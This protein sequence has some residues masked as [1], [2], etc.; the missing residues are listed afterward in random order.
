VSEGACA[1]AQIDA[2]VA[3]VRSVGTAPG[4][5][6]AFRRPGTVPAAH[7]G[8]IQH[9]FGTPTSA[10]HASPSPATRQSPQVTR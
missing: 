4:P 3:T 6:I 10:D 9:L 2:V 7:P 5:M 1:P 8:V